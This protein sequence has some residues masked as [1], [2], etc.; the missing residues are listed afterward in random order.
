MSRSIFSPLMKKIRHTE[1]MLCGSTIKVPDTFSLAPDAQL[2]SSPSWR[3]RVPS[4]RHCGSNQ[5]ILRQC[6]RYHRLLLQ[7][8]SAERPLQKLRRT[9][10]P[11]G[12]NT[13]LPTLSRQRQKRRAGE[14]IN[15]SFLGLCL[16]P[17]EPHKSIVIEEVFALLLFFF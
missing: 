16:P 9:W 8:I 6:L 15:Y 2:Q 7:A 13:S 12:G 5:S 1:Y 14:K 10:L 17:I 4:R 11:A 3:T